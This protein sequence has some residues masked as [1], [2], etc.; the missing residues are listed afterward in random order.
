MNPPL[1]WHGVGKRTRAALYITSRGDAVALSKFE[2]YSRVFLN[3]DE[4]DFRF[5]NNQPSY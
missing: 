5:R 1:A 4:Q 3:T 2:T